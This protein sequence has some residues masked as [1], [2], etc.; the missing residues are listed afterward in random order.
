MRTVSLQ[1]DRH[2]PP[3]GPRI[4]GIPGKNHAREILAFDGENCIISLYTSTGQGPLV[5]ERD[6]VRAPHHRSLTLPALTFSHVKR[7]CMLGWRAMRFADTRAGFR[8]LP[9][10]DGVNA[11]KT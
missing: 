5:L 10:G 4:A 2:P 7:D 6:V 1:N 8:S 11:K 3:G 9:S